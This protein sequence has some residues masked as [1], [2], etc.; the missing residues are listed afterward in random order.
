M[1]FMIYV[2]FEEEARLAL[3]GA[4]HR[5]EL[6][7]QSLADFHAQHGE[8]VTHE[9]DALVVELDSASRHYAKSLQ[10]L[11]ELNLSAAR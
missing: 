11:E 7:K 4:A 9:H 3:Q 10:D 6:A 8:V 5:L 1:I 2:S